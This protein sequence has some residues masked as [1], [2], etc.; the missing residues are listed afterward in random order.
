MATPNNTPTTP[1]FPPSAPTAPSPILRRRDTGCAVKLSA[2]LV[3][4]QIT[5][6][7]PTSCKC[8]PAHGPGDMA[9]LAGVASSALSEGVFESEKPALDFAK[10]LLGA[11]VSFHHIYV[12]YCNS[13]GILYIQQE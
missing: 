11:K 2:T 1:S 5:H 4:A 9:R 3:P 6:G 12:L 10:L 13:E 8:F 7:A